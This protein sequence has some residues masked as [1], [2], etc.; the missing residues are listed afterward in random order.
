MT[1]NENLRI[2]F[3]NK[4]KF[5]LVKYKSVV[6]RLSNIKETWLIEGNII[7]TF[8]EAIVSEKIKQ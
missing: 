3:I 8:H 2:N 4:I 7:F 6:Y 1:S 5:P